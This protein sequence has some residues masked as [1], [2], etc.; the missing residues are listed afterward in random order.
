MFSRKALAAS[1]TP[2]ASIFGSG[3]LIIVPVLERTL[4]ALAVV[5]VAGVCG[6]AW[7]VGSAIRHNVTTVEKLADEGRLDRVTGRLEDG[8]DLVIVV[9]YVISVALYLRIMSQYVVDYAA[10]G[11]DVAERALACGAVVA[12]VAVGIVRGFGG[13]E[14]ME[15]LAL[16]A[17]LAITTIL[18]AALFFS[19]AG[20]LLG[21]GISLPPVPGKGLANVLLVLG[22]IVITVQGF[23][24]VRYLSEEYDRSTRVWACRLSQLVSSSIYVGFVAVATPSWASAPGTAADTTLLDITDRV[25]PLLS[26]AARPHRRAEPVQRRHGRH[27]RGPRQ[28]PPASAGPDAWRAPLRGERC[29]GDPSRLDGA[30]L[31][32]HRRRL[33]RLRRLLRDPV[34]D[35]GTNL[36]SP[37]G[38]ARLWRCSHWPWRPITLLAEPAG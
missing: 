5:G 7:L 35:R 11:S 34:R 26:S 21:G 20:N 33:S 9:A 37:P 30:D 18:G 1:V 16:M 4:G 6:F 22:G 24:T 14:L 3:F 29:G 27:R 12:I 23:E 13:L 19:D 17:V 10:G 32:H 15:R 28:P 38:E 2:L 31:H 8:A 36:R 25:V